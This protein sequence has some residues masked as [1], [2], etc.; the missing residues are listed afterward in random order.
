MNTM[1]P[2]SEGLRAERRTLKASLFAILVIIGMLLPMPGEGREIHALC[3]L[4][5]APAA[6]L[7]AWLLL[8]GIRARLPGSPLRAALPTW[9]VVVSLGGP[10][11]ILQGLTGRSPSWH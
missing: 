9:A 10:I 3:D 5:H 4:M 1:T 8:Q 2:A 6:G 7:L 11:E